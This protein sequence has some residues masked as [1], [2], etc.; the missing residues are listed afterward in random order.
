M[1]KENHKK[2]FWVKSILN[3]NTVT[4]IFKGD[5]SHYPRFKIDWSNPFKVI[6]LLIKGEKCSCCGKRIPATRDYLVRES[7][8]FLVATLSM[9]KTCTSEIAVNNKV[10]DFAVDPNNPNLAYGTMMPGYVSTAPMY[11][12]AGK[13][14]KNDI[15]TR[16]SNR[17]SSEG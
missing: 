5:N 17:D 12:V 11:A 8:G 3:D 13:E 2:S 9:C 4:L 14:D 16:K 10:T 7:N 15:N 1:D 6:G